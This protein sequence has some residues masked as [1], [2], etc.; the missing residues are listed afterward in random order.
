M[1]ASWKCD[2]VVAPNTTN[3][4]WHSDTWRDRPTRRP[5][6]AKT[7]TK[8]RV[9]VAVR[10][11]EPSSRAGSTRAKATIT[12][13]SRAGKR[14]LRAWVRRARAP[15]A[16]RAAWVV[17]SAKRPLREKTSTANS[18]MNDRLVGR[19]ARLGRAATH[20]VSSDSPT[21]IPMAPR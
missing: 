18:T 6:L 15:P 19:P 16:T 20:F 21:P 13:S 1:P 12:T 17:S 7:R 11:R 10:S 4:A 5:R 8:A 3:T 2:R 14:R 9:D